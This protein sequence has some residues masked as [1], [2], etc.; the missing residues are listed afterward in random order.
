MATSEHTHF[1]IR[2]KR[3]RIMA[4]MSL[5]DL[6]NILGN[7]VTKQALN[8]YELGIMRPTST[9]LIAVSKALDV[10][11]DYFL[12]SDSV[13][14]KNIS[15]RK[16]STL[17]K[18]IEDSIIEKAKDYGERFLELEKLLGI[19]TK[20]KN[21][22]SGI[23]IRNENDAEHASIELRKVLDLGNNPISNIVEMLEQNGILV[24]LINEVD[25]IDGFSF[26]AD[27]HIPVVIINTRDRSIERIRFTVIHELAH[28]LLN[29]ELVNTN[30]NKYEERLC[31]LFSSCFILPSA[32]LIEMIGGGHR[33]YINIKELINIK[34]Y[35]GISIRAVI[36]RLQYLGIISQSYY[37][38]WMIYL[39]KTYGQKSEPG[40][41][42]GNE[43]L[44]LFEQL[45][46]RAL[47]EDMISTSKAANLMN[48]SIA[49]IR[50]NILSGSSD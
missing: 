2:L 46:T 8:K 1:G 25:E 5:Q 42:K 43:E 40:N 32:K 19:D 23:K 35:Y 45:I 29:I 28:L 17:S 38:R 22:L 16:K 27:N 3:A 26:I 50:K 36:H 20:F 37:Q 34:E 31:H 11:P 21:P 48:T 39:S 47:S 12:K 6:S 9:V 14:I 18:K 15:F 24:I 33:R 44:R 7:L 13:T 10:K 30:D 41:Y 49:I 4:G